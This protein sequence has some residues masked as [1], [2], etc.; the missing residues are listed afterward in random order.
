MLEGS[1]L[2]I[3]FSYLRT[4]QMACD[5]NAIQE[6][7]P[8]WLLN[9]AIKNPQVSLSVQEHALQGHVGTVKKES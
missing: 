8:L 4:F 3:I 6:D 7:G 5:T 2:I 9:F 1:N